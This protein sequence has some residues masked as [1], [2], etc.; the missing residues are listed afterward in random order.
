MSLSN[1]WVVIFLI[2]PHLS[3]YYYRLDIVYQLT[4]IWQFLVVIISLFILYRN[5]TTFNILLIFYMTL[6]IFSAFLNDTFN[7]GIFY[8]IAVFTGFCIY[9]SYAMRNINELIKG[10]Y[11]LFATV[12]FLN[13]FTLLIG[14]IAVSPD[15]LSTNYLLG[16]KNAIAMTA[17]PT[18]PLIYLY[19]YMI[20]NKLK[21]FPF[22][23]ILICAVSLYLSESGTG[24][25]ISFLA[26]L[27][28]VLPKKY[29]PSFTTYFW[30]YI[31]AFFTIVVFRLQELL[32]GDFI[33]NVLHKDMTFTGRTYIWDLVLNLIKKSWLIGYGRGNQIISQHFA[34]LNETHN[35]LLE[36]MMYSGILGVLFFLIIL[37][38]VGHKLNSNK[39]HILSKILSFSIFAY[40]I[41]GLTE[42]VFYKKEFWI[43]LVISYGIRHIIRSLDLKKVAHR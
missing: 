16:G 29:F 31:V 21:A 42:S 22:L 40:L 6:V 1:R 8:S 25:V 20:H 2:L 14:G 18:I 28:V 5:L 34:N 35:G 36:I 15:G 33:I 4:L 9:I 7:P 24:I 39:D 17:L 13:F 10:L 19:S 27:F 26:I 43:L 3:I 30:T 37:L 32:F 12:V 23:L 38:L 41:I 11:Y